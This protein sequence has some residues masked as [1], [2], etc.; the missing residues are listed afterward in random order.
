MDILKT[1]L[2]KERCAA[3]GEVDG[4]SSTHGRHGDAVNSFQHGKVLRAVWG[5]VSRAFRGRARAK[6]PPAAEDL[7]GTCERRANP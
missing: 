7:Q 2:H 4:G 5:K 3:Q 6:E 1:A